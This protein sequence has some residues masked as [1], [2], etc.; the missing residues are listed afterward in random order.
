LI[1]A[2]GI[3]FAGIL[4]LMNDLHVRM[5][6]LIYLAIFVHLSAAIY[7]QIFGVV[8]DNDEECA[9]PGGH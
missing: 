2:S 4:E 3:Q 9:T 5:A 1:E 7:H 8:D 6:N